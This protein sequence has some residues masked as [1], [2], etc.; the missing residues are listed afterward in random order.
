MNNN[1]L[2]EKVGPLW[3]LVYHTYNVLRT[4]WGGL[5][6]RLLFSILLIAKMQG[7]DIS[8]VIVTSPLWGFYILFN[9]VSALY[10][11]KHKKILDEISKN[12]EKLCIRVPK[13]SN[14]SIK[15]MMKSGAKRCAEVMK[16]SEKYDKE[17]TQE[18]LEE[19]DSLID[20]KF[21]EYKDVLDA[22]NQILVMGDIIEEAVCNL[23]KKDIFQGVDKVTKPDG[24]DSEEK[25]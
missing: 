17:F 9:L 1:I 4:G 24:D 23:Q 16:E 19:V 6:D 20:K 2:T 21:S 12:P 22:E 14:D 5:L 10:D 25:K 8:W 18:V 11:Y 15:N 3:F 13:E 7:A